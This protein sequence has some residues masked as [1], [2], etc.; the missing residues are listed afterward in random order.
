M[1]EFL[2][3]III[4]DPHQNAP[5]FVIGTLSFNVDKITADLKAKANNGWVNAQIKR[6]RDGKLYIE[7]D[8]YQ[9]DQSGPPR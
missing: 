1:A 6:S 4:K 2:D 8:T 7:L 5:S 3:G 9:R